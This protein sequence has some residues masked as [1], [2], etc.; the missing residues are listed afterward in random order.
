MVRNKND[1]KRKKTPVKHTRCSESVLIQHPSDSAQLRA[2]IFLQILRWKSYIHAE[3]DQVDSHL[4][5]SY[6]HKPMSKTLLTLTEA[7]ICYISQ[8]ENNTIN[9]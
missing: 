3:F 1:E 8:Y 4:V 2:N 6:S 5:Y 9:D 7:G